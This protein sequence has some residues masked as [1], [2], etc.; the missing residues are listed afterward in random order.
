MSLPAREQ[1]APTLED[2]FEA[3]SRAHAI[4]VSYGMY[5]LQD[6]VDVLWQAAL[7]YGLV[8]AYGIDWVEQQMAVCFKD[9]PR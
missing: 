3:R 2:V 8:E 5:A 9:V 1:S 6:S 4:L 7:D